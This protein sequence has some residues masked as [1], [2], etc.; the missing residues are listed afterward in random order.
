[1]GA[2]YC[3]GMA[4]TKE[5]IS[6]ETVYELKDESM[7]NGRSTKALGFPHVCLINQLIWSEGGEQLKW[8][9]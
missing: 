4:D 5:Q 2:Q 9:V 7:L 6:A 3:I 8:G 1:M